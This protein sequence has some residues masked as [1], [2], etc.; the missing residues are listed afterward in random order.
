MAIA[1]LDEALQNKP[2]YAGILGIEKQELNQVLG[3]VKQDLERD[4]SSSTKDDRLKLSNEDGQK[5]PEPN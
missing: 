3:R 2:A 4:A 1:I 5:H